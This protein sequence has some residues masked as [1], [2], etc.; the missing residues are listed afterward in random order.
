MGGRNTTG[1]FDLATDLGE[2][3]DLSK[4][5]PDVLKM[6][7][8]KFAAWRKAWRVATDAEKPAPTDLYARVKR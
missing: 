1:L 5:K 2:T 6:M 8:G 3:R 7:Q 4:E